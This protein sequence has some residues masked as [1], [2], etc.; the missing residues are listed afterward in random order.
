MCPGKDH[1]CLFVLADKLGGINQAVEAIKKW[2]EEERE[3]RKKPPSQIPE[4]ISHI[5][6]STPHIPEPGPHTP[7]SIPQIPESTPQI[8]GPG[9]QTPEPDSQI[10]DLEL[11]SEQEE[12]ACPPSANKL[13]L[14]KYSQMLHRYFLALFFNKT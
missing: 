13:P 5:P 8:P 14:T 4:S 2:R 9:P 7:E 1:Q 3:S 12:V 6:E 11:I 10:S